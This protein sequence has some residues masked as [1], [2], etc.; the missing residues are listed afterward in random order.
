M[1]QALLRL[2]LSEGGPKPKGQMSP[3]RMR[4]PAHPNPVPK[5]EGSRTAFTA[6]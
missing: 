5:G 3:R 4:E 1:M 6:R 2:P